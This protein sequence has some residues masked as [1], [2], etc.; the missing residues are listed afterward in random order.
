MNEKH[1]ASGYSASSSPMDKVKQKLKLVDGLDGQELTLIEP[2]GKGQFGTVFLVTDPSKTRF[3]A[4]KC[5]S[6]F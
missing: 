5:I 2:I 1:E 3:Y 6:K 4:L